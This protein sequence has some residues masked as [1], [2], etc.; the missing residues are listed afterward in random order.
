MSAFCYHLVVLR[1]RTVSQS[2]SVVRSAHRLLKEQR[3]WQLCA[4]VAAGVANSSNQAID[5]QGALF[6][7]WPTWEADL[8]RAWTDILI[9]FSLIH[10]SVCR[11][12]LETKHASFRLWEKWP[13]RIDQCRACRTW[14]CYHSNQLSIMKEKRYGSAGELDH[15]NRE[16]AVSF[17]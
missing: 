10:R 6:V 9:S 5:F 11:G 1:L 16:S 13:R 12:V 2:V 7:I 14:L 4:F 15:L 3:S 17:V 8:P